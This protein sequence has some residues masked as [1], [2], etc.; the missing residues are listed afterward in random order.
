MPS[1]TK[2]LI[3][4][5]LMDVRETVSTESEPQAGWPEADR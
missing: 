2:V 4:G 5:R 3:P 1:P